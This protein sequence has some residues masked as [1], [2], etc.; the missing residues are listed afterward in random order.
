MT[1]AGL[2]WIPGA[3]RA[4][5]DLPG[6]SLVSPRLAREFG[7]DEL[8]QWGLDPDTIDTAAQVISE[9]TSNAV[10]HGGDGPMTLDLTEEGQAL[11]ITVTD[12]G[13]PPAPIQAGSPVTGAESGRG[14]AIVEALAEAWDHHHYPSTATAVWAVIAVRRTTDSRTLP[15]PATDDTG[16]LT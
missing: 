2:P 5:C 10:E 3:R 1:T 12:R 14:L 8:Q 4:L 16:A 7:R 9:L 6:T 15:I 11:R 13:R